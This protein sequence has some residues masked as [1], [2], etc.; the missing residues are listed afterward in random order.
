M[1]ERSSRRSQSSQ[2]RVA[3]LAVPLV[4]GV[5]SPRQDMGQPAVWPQLC[6]PCRVAWSMLLPLSGPQFPPL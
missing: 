6:R 5:E 1:R 4:G 2:V 3:R